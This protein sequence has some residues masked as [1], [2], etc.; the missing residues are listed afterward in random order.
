MQIIE[1]E[2]EITVD[3]DTLGSTCA[4]WDTYAAGDD[5]AQWD[6]GV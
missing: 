5:I 6:S 4:S 3:S 2:S 1:R